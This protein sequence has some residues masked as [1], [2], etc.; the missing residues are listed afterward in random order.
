MI[1]IQAVGST[2]RKSSAAS[3]PPAPALSR[4]RTRRQKQVEPEVPES[5][6][7]TDT[8]LKN[9]HQEEDFPSPPFDSAAR[10]REGLL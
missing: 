10:T 6:A 4:A 8:G 3:N 2:R 1:L 7:D 5:D 9:E